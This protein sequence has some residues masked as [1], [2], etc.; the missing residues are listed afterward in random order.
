MNVYDFDKTIYDGDSTVDFYLYCL[1]KKPT[2]IK[3]VFTQGL[4][5]FLYLI[6]WCDKTE[7]KQRFHSFLKGIDDIDF[8]VRD[9][10]EVNSQKIKAWYK[11]RR[12]DD[13]VIISATAEF[14][15]KPVVPSV[16]ASRVDK[17]TGIYESKNCYGEE[18][19]KRFLEKFP[20]GIIDEFYSDSLSDY[21]IA[22][23]ARFSFVVKG[24]DINHWK[25]H[26]KG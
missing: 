23:M 15:L 11:E 14:L 13:D 4:G 9:F 16:I 6:K 19:A 20:D 3:F 1:R 26:E 8:Y 25:L 21:P 7:F 12:R 17:Y 22:S 24:N 2:L 18:K 10:W 5:L